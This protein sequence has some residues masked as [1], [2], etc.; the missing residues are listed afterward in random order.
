V[1]TVAVG[2][3]TAAEAQACAEAGFTHGQGVY[4]GRPRPMEQI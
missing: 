1:K 2:V 3:E 4:L